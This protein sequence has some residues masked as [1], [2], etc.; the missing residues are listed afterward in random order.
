MISELR[1]QVASREPALN[2]E[3]GQRIADLL[4]DLIGR[5]QPIEIKIFGDDLDQ[6][7]SLAVKTKALLQK[8]NGLADIQSGIIV[9]GPTITIVPDPVKLITVLTLRLPIFSPRLKH[10]MKEYR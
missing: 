9:D 6:L 8:L 5:P 3:F 4:G 7:R 1:R 2:I 10:I